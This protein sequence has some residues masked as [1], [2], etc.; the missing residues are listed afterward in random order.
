M[1]LALC[2]PECVC[3]CVCV[4]VCKL[5]FPNGS[6][7]A[8]L[9]CCSESTWNKYKQIDVFSLFHSITHTHKHTH[10]CDVSVCVCVVCVF[11]LLCV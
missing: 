5:I 11:V 10:C 4:C 3:V 8:S 7:Q 2:T 9:Q 1:G 6:G